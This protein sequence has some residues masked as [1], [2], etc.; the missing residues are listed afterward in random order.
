[1]MY[2]GDVDAPYHNDR[3]SN[4]EADSCIDSTANFGTSHCRSFRRAD[5]WAS[6]NAANYVASNHAPSHQR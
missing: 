1:M 2:P 3:F 5:Y 6:N 4:S